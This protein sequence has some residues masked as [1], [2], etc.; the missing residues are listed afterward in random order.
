MHPQL[1]G[2]GHWRERFS[3]VPR[4]VVLSGSGLSVE[5]GLSLYRAAEGLWESHDV[6]LVCNIQTWKA[7]AALVHR[8]YDDRRAQSAQAQPNAGHRLLAD[9]EN[10]GAVLVT[11]NV[12]TLLEQAG[13]QHVLHL[14]GA[15]DQMLCTDCDHTWTVPLTLCWNMETDRCPKCRS[16]KGVKPGVVFFGEQAPNYAPWRSMVANLR[17]NDV[18][19]TV[20]SSGEVVN[21]LAIPGAH[22]NWLAN[23]GPSS[24]LPSDQFEKIWYAPITHSIQAIADAWKTHL[25]QQ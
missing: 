24:A 10:E 4:L 16:G 6:N 21:P 18:V 11:Q 12:D 9:L 23:L 8:F 7:H 25:D 1:T 2:V 13:A 22:Q 20:G 17:P 19:L 5:S 3:P 15:I 14:H